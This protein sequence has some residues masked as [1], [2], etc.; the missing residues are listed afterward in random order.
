[1]EVVMDA[2]DK[3][4]DPY[5]QELMGKMY[6]GF[7]KE[8]GEDWS[9]NPFNDDIMWMT[10]A[11]ARAYQAFHEE[12]YRSRQRK[13]FNLVYDRAGAM[14]WA[15]AC[16]GE[17]KIRRKRL[18]QRPCRDCSRA[19]YIRLPKIRAIWIVRLRFMTGK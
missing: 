19:C 3:T 12:I 1:M 18:Y 4:K 11:C 6:R 2:W 15:E 5:Y 7:V 16:S 10:I 9:N 17:S 14:I 8:F 13:H